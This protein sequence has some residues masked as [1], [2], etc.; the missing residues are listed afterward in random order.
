MQHGDHVH[1]ISDLPN[2]LCYSTCELTAKVPA[3]FR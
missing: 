3:S 1:F 2:Q